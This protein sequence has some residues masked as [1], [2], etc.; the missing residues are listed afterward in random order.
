MVVGSVQPFE[1]NQSPMAR[2][3]TT[4]MRITTA[5]LETDQPSTSSIPPGNCDVLRDPPFLVRMQEQLQVR[6]IIIIKFDTLMSPVLRIT[7]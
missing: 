7:L 2:L 6:S 3:S 1:L 5:I 4:S